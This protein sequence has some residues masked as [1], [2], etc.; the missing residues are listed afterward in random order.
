MR[1]ASQFKLVYFFAMLYICLI[2]SSSLMGQK[3]VATSWGVI[4]GASLICPFWFLLNDIVA[5]VYGFKI[6]AYF[7]ISAII[8]EFVFALVTLLVINL[9][10]PQGLDQQSLFVIFS[11]LLKVYV[12]QSIGVSLAWYANTYII[13]RWKV[14]VKGKYFWLRSIGSSCVGVVIFCLVSVVPSL[15]LVAA[16]NDFQDIIV[17]LIWSF[18]L[19][20][21][22]LTFFV[23]PAGLVVSLIKSV[24]QF[25]CYD[26]ANG[27]N[28][29][30]D[31]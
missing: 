5:E 6:T 2:I 15:I 24:E 4:S 11:P 27:F 28:P 18:A 20:M 19:K 1:G 22:V 16:V 23:Y 31:V 8:M 7:F 30:K 29:F 13:T 14:L 3:I 17:M 9:P 12:L 25:D 26:N 10:S 21:I